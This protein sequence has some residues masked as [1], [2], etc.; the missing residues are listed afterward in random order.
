ML[1]R[2]GFLCL[3]FLELGCLS[4]SGLAMILG[5]SGMGEVVDM[6]GTLDVEEQGLLLASLRGVT[7]FCLDAKGK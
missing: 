3:E 5:L 7:F 6:I 4:E 2:Y 1:A